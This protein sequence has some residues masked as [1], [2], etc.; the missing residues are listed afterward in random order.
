MELTNEAPDY[1]I[2]PFSANLIYLS[3]QNIFLFCLYVCNLHLCLNVRNSGVP[4]S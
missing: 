1:V 3:N 2:S 4:N